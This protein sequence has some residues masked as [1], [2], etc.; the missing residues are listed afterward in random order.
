[1]NKLITFYERSII[2]NSD[3]N[4]IV[5][6]LINYLEKVPSI[7]PNNA[8]RIEYIE[9]GIINKE[10]AAKVSAKIKFK[11]FHSCY[12]NLLMRGDKYVQCFSQKPL[13]RGCHLGD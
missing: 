12:N 6:K 8:V 5:I 2:Y 7:V 3:K 4:K 11:K 13:R 10:R 9:N 1:V